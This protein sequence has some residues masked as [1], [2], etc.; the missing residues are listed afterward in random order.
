MIRALKTLVVV[1]VLAAVV[2]FYPPIRLA[3]LVLVGRATVCPYSQAV[4][5]AANLSEQVDI[6]RRILKASRLVEKDPKGFHLWS[7]P[8]GMYW[9]PA[10]SDYAL[11]WD[12][13]EQER[14]IYGMGERAVHRGDIVLDCGSNVGVFTREALNQGA[15]LVVAIE[16]AP[17]NLE[18][19]RR[20]FADEIA[21]GRVLVYPKGVW[22]KDAFLTLTVASENSAADSVVMHPEKSHEGPRVELTTIDKIVAELKL[23]RVDFIKMDIEG[24]EQNALIGA[25]ATLAK[26]HPR[27]SLSAYHRPDDPKRIPELVRAGW[28]GY[29]MECGPC[30][31]AKTFIRPDILYFY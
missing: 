18:C 6:Q 21:H 24:A 4:R 22:D 29:R 31:D 28:S 16:I 19:M 3:A 2:Y 13:A 9:M 17:E 12:L 26:Y 25:R 1:V 23:E 8:R 5:S 30:A 10:G 15:G 14:R 7:T 27:M 20:N 11:P